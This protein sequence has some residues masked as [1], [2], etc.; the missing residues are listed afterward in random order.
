MAFIG[1]KERADAERAKEQCHGK[2]VEGRD[3]KV[4]LHI[5]GFIFSFEYVLKLILT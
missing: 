5:H 4:S 2:K 3:L 1:F